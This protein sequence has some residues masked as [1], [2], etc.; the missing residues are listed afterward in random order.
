MSGFEK[1]YESD[2][3]FAYRH[4]DFDIQVKAAFVAGLR[5]TLQIVADNY[6][7]SNE[8]FREIEA[9]AKKIEKGE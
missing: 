3:A 5:H 4:K 9:E 7:D 6:G 1:W 8:I 2:D